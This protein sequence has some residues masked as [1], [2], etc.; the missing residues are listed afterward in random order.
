MKI[1]TEIVRLKKKFPFTISRGTRTH[2][3]NIF[4]FVSD[5]SYTGIGECDLGFLDNDQKNILNTQELLEN[6]IHKYVKSNFCIHDIWQQAHEEKLCKPAQAALDMALWDLLAKR[7]NQQCYKLFGL[8]NLSSPTS[9]TLGIMPVEQ[10]NERVHLLLESRY[11]RFLKI[12]LGSQHGIDHDQELFL[13]IKQAAQAF[14]VSLRVDANGGWNL[15]DAKTMCSWLSHHDI[16]YVE[17][18]MSPLLDNAMPELFKNRS[19]PIFLD[20]SCNL[21]E[22]ILKIYKY[23]DGI[24]IK[25]MKC[26]GITE[27]LRMVA[28]ARA[29]KL[30]TM[31]GCMSESSVALSAGASIASLFD[32]I[33][34]DSAFNLDPDPAQGLILSKGSVLCSELPGHGGSL[35]STFTP[36]LLSTWKTA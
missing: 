17:Q 33:D 35:C 31:I 29:C 27:A 1:W 4:L 30:K 28:V 19:L 2:S 34:L 9:I 20:E 12:K 18:P 3:N 6:F 14:G 16:E 11:F 22:D 21:A 8:K 32:Y 13:K 25:L 10:I 26:G 5:T 7:S 15:A 36:N 23:T 24:N